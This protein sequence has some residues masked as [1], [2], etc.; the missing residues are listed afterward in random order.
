M[1][2]D[3]FAGRGLRALGAGEASEDDGR[4]SLSPTVFERT[5]W[6]GTAISDH[7]PVLVDVAPRDR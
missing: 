1:K 2:I 7:D 4:T 5:R 6:E 3:W